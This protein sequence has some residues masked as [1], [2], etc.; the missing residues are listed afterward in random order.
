MLIKMNAHFGKKEKEKKNTR[1]L[2]IR[3]AFGKDK[4]S[5]ATP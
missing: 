1:V 4:V 3:I 2:I 5:E